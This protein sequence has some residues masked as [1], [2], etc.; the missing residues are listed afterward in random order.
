MNDTNLQAYALSKGIKTATKDM[1]SQEKIGLAMKM[2]LEKTADY[3]GNY[4]KENETLAGS[5]TTAKAAFK[6]FLSGVGDASEVGAALVKAG[7][8]IGQKLTALLPSLV[9]GISALLDSLIPELPPMLESLLPALIDGAVA[10]VNGLVKAGGQIVNALMGI[11]P[12]LLE[13]ALLL[14]ETIGSALI[15]NIDFVLDPALQIVMMLG[16]ALIDNLPK[17]ADAAKKLIVKLC[18]FI[19]NNSEKIVNLAVEIITTLATEIAKNA[20]KLVKPVFGAIL[21]LGKSLFDGAVKLG[22]NL[23]E[24]IAKAFGY[25]VPKVEGLTAKTYEYTDAEEEAID[26]MY[27]SIDALDELQDNYAKSASAILDETQLTEDLWKELQTLCDETGYVDDANKDRAEYILGELNKALDTEYYLN[28]NIIGQYQQMQEEIDTLIQKRRAELL[29]NTMGEKYAAAKSSH[30]TS[31]QAYAAAD[32]ALTAERVYV[33]DY[34]SDFLDKH[35]NV[36]NLIVDRMEATGESYADAKSFIYDI[37]NSDWVQQFGGIEGN[38]KSGENG[39]MGYRWSDD[40]EKNIKNYKTS[41]AEKEEDLENAKAALNAENATIYQYETAENQIMNGDYEGATST[42]LDGVEG[43]LWSALK[44]G[45]IS[46]SIDTTALKSDLKDS[47]SYL[48]FYA[49]QLTKGVDGYTTDGLEDLSEALQENATLYKEYMDEQGDA[50][51]S[52]YGQETIANALGILLDA[53]EIAG[54]LGGSSDV[55]HAPVDIDEIIPKTSEGIAIS[56]VS[57]ADEEKSALTGMTEKL[58]TLISLMGEKLSELIL[59]NNAI[60]T[61]MSTLTNGGLTVKMNS[62]EFGRMVRTVKE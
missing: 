27:D 7:K 23:G 11:A 55:L 57:F 2:F 30:S 44:G 26:A 32:R 58:E 17:L 54:G 14:M 45:D 3:A 60:A 62:R 24:G 19:G 22:K 36:F 31:V 51:E 40:E 53:Q 38:W 50:V 1:T 34:W 6:N 37:R 42:M 46:V 35:Y 5:L 9:S 47:L 8:V 21:T 61:S 59:G 33:D 43:A 20:P 18:T 25:A 39:F 4:A 41:V 49:D 52:L 56:P 10:L 15:D 29:L 12:D 16:Q 13:A 28:G 48:Q